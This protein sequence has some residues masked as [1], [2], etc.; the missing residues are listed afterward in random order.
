MIQVPSL[1]LFPRQ[2]GL[3]LCFGTAL[4]D[5]SSTVPELLSDILR[6]NLVSLILDGIMEESRDDLLFVATEFADQSGYSPQ[7]SDIGCLCSLS[8]LLLMEFQP[9]CLCF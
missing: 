4:N 1:P 9:T 2:L 6:G 8:E 7:V 3:R 5:F